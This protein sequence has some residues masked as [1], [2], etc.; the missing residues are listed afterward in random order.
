[1]NA[2]QS[3][4]EGQSSCQL[5]INMEVKGKVLYVCRAIISSNRGDRCL[6]TVNRNAIQFLIIISITLRSYVRMIA[7]S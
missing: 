6:N 5:I 7:G 2:S 3:T 4:S 1:M